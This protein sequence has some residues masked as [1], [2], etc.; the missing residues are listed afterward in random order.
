MPENEKKIQM[1]ITDPKNGYPEMI[2]ECDVKIYLNGYL[3]KTVY[4]LADNVRSF[5]KQIKVESDHDIKE[6]EIFIQLTRGKQKKE[7]EVKGLLRQ[8]LITGWQ[9]S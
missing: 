4:S 1:D 5:I 8:V 6:T 9:D 2:G 3:I 7:I